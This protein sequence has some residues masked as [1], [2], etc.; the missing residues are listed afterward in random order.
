M[1][2]QRTVL[3]PRH[4]ENGVWVP[5]CFGGFGCVDGVGVNDNH[6]DMK[7]TRSGPFL[8]LKGIGTITLGRLGEKNNILRDDIVTWKQRIEDSLY[9]GW[10][11]Y[12]TR[13]SLPDGLQD[14][15]KDSLYASRCNDKNA[16]VTVIEDIEER[17]VYDVEYCLTEENGASPTLLQL[18][19]V[20]EVSTGFMCY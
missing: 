2:T 1:D 17:S 20:L 4:N 3:R 10:V 19:K 15:A 18:L 13:S 7:S 11:T 12:T 16:S 14:F 8:L 6:F 9:V 5:S